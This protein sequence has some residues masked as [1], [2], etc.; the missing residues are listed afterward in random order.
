MSSVIK[1]KLPPSAFIKLYRSDLS[2]QSG[3]D[4]V[5]KIQSSS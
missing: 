2:L 4:K 5:C 1:H 3:I